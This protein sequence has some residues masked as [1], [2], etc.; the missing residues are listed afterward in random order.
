MFLRNGGTINVGTLAVIAIKQAFARHDLHQLQSRCVLRRLSFRN[1]FMN[2]PDRCGSGLPENVQNLDLCVRR[3]TAC[4]SGPHSPDYLL[5]ILSYVNWNMLC[6]SSGDVDRNQGS[7]ERSS[8]NVTRTLD[9]R[10][11][12]V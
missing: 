9:A 1:F 4:L 3:P 8:V 7:S 2:K 10:R 5:R 6:V 11:R 12:G